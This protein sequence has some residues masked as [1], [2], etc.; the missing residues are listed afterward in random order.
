MNYAE[1]LTDLRR[2]I[3][4]VNLESKRIEK[5]FGVSIPQL[6]C[7]RYLYGRSGYKASHSEIKDYLSLNASTVTGII[8]RLEK[9]GLVAKLPR[10]TDR[11]VSYVT[12]TEHGAQLIKGPTVLI[13]ERLGKK[14]ETLT[15]AE[16]DELRR[17]FRVISSFLGVEDV[18]A[19]PIITGQVHIQQDPAEEDR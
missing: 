14:L 15:P 1:I 3:R 12:I 13:H 5:E 16:I 7:L 8:N 4:S 11:R 18:D 17:A 6:L 2:I 9:K 10:E 19:S